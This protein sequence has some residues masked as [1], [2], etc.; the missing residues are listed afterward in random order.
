MS[1]IILGIMLKDYA[2]VF[3][4]FHLEQQNISS[5]D[6]NF[7]IGCS[8]GLSGREREHKLE[9]NEKRKSGSWGISSHSTLLC[10][11][12]TSGCP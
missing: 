1:V 4:W 8:L 6:Q 11:W 5:S 9:I 10:G 3:L 2:S 12:A 7:F